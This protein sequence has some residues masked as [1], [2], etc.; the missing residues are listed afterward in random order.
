[1]WRVCSA[2]DCSLMSGDKK[3]HRRAHAGWE[4]GGKC[5]IRQRAKYLILKA[6]RVA[7]WL[8]A[9]VLKTSR[10][11]TLSWVRIPPLPPQILITTPLRSLANDTS[12]VFRPPNGLKRFCQAAERLDD[13][14]ARF[15]GGTLKGI[16]R[17]CDLFQSLSTGQAAELSRQVR[18]GRQ[19]RAVARIEKLQR[20]TYRNRICHG[21][22]FYTPQ[23]KNT[24]QVRSCAGHT[25]NRKPRTEVR[26]FPS[27]NGRIWLGPLS[28]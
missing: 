10:G 1:M 25:C 24:Y 19:R 6:G 16:C 17:L 5:S 13:R 9:L 12:G 21:D 2:V 18:N 15:A 11:E 8:M 14:G 20:P 4:I 23:V 27:S 22:S 7:E 26:G 3:H 28:E